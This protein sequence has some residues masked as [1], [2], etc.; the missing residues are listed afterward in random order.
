MKKPNFDPGL[1]QQYSAEISRVIRRDGQF[2]VRRHGTTW[3]DIHPYLYFLNAPWYNF[4]GFMVAGFIAVNF[5][6]A[7][8]Y[9]LIGV[10]NL[11]GAEAAT[12]FRRFLN[13]FF[14]SAQTLTTV[15]Y[16]TI[17][18]R[19]VLVN[20]LASFE[21]MMGLMGFAVVTGFLVGRVSRPT[22]RIGFSDT[23]I[24]APYQDATSLQFRLVNRGVSNLM[25][26]DAS[27][28]LMTVVTTDGRLER[29]F[30]RLELE[31]DSV[32]FLALTWTIVHAID[33]NSPL[34]GKSAADLKRLKAEVLILIKGTDD[35]FSQV[36]HARYSYRYDE[37]VWGAKF[38]PAFEI[39]EKGT[40]HLDVDKVSDHVKLPSLGP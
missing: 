2:N 20:L 40:M 8:T 14:F 37:I 16:G 27:V 4:F 24:V 23:M 10:Q 30:E 31:R 26:L 36:V 39:D 29:K 1:T 34:F 5:I 9:Y 19:G 28:M 32:L 18:P 6:F 38:T 21:A 33:A 35:M 17:A 22:A 7:L 11:Q 13:A 25:E 12:E 3:Q 15:G